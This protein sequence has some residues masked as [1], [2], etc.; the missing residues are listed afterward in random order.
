IGK[1]EMLHDLEM[2]AY[3]RVMD[4]NLRGV[5]FGM[6]HAVRAMMDRGGSIVNW[7]SVGGLGASLFGSTV[8]SASKGGVVMATKSA[9]VKYGSKGIR[10]NAI[11]PGFILTEGMGA[12]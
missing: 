11:C 5:V 6:K 4:V 8:Y 12:S 1:S 9:A 10:V 3:D 7:S 2:E